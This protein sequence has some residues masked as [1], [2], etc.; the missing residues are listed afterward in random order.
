MISLSVEEHPATPV[1]RLIRRICLLREQ[2]DA[3]GAHSLERDQLP[4]AVQLAR[5][6][7]GPDALPEDELRRIFARESERAAEAITIAGLIVQQ[8]TPHA[9][10]GTSA[11]SVRATRDREPPAPSA[12]GRASGNTTPAIADLLDAMLANE[13]RA[14]SR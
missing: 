2:G 14:G 13:G 10:G 8:L 12:R 6:K 11:A 4:A 5:T 3:A 1:T 9:L 7:L